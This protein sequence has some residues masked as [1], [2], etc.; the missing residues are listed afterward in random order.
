[1]RF[2]KPYH[3]A[4]TLQ[5]LIMTEAKEAGGKELSMLAKSFASLEMLKLRLRMKPAPKPVDTTKMSKATKQSSAPSF[6]E[7]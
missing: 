2:S 7:Q 4:V 3:H 5:N 1:M 6:T